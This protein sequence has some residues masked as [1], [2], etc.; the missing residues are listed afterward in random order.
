MYI[1]TDPADKE[2]YSVKRKSLLTKRAIK[3]IY[4]EKF[5]PELTKNSNY[6]STD[7]VAWLHY[8]DGSCGKE[9]LEDLFPTMEIVTIAQK[10]DFN[11]LYAKATKLMHLDFIWL[12][13]AGRL[14]YSLNE[15]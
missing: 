10:E 5:T 11:S 6:R 12:G 9:G 15:F 4:M 2:R 14:G 7:F 8:C 1:L 3:Y 13:A